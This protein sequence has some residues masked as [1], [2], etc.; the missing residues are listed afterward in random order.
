M[1][2]RVL[3]AATI[4]CLASLWMSPAA[5][6]FGNCADDFYM[7][8]FDERLGG[9]NCDI[10][11]TVDIRWSGGSAKMRVIKPHDAPSD[12]NAAMMGRVRELAA[13]VGAAMDQV[14][15]VSIADVTVLMTGMRPTEVNLVAQADIQRKPGLG[16]ECAVAFYKQPTPVS[17]DEFVFFYAHELFHCI[18]YRT[19]PAA[20]DAAHDLWWTEGTAEYFAHLARPGTTTGDA[21]VQNFDVRSPSV[22]LLQMQY[23]NVVFFAWLAQTQGPGAIASFAR[24]MSPGA[25]QL[26]AL[27]GA[28]S[29]DMWLEFAKAYLDRRIQLPGGR[30]LPSRPLMGDKLDVYSTRDLPLP[31]SP[32]VL[33]RETVVFKRGHKYQLSLNGRPDDAR[34]QW[35]KP[36]DGRWGDTPSEI[37][38]CDAD[39]D[40]RVLWLTTR[41]STAGT[42][43]VRAGEH[44]SV[45]NCLVGSWEMTQAS[46][47]P[48]AQ[49]V[50]CKHAQSCT[51]GGSLLLTFNGDVGAN[52]A[53]TGTYAYNGVT[54][55]GRM[56]PS[57]GVISFTKRFDG[58]GHTRWYTVQN[59]LFMS[60]TD[61]FHPVGTVHTRTV[62]RDQGR[63]SVKDEPMLA[64]VGLGPFLG[65]RYD[66]HGNSLH[67]GEPPGYGMNNYSFDFLRV[68]GVE[69][70]AHQGSGR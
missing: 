24:S 25:G 51:V 68:S 70:G 53:A 66:C 6:A 60:F 38:P 17:V 59:V 62:M 4:A 21:W 30:P 34:V 54:V 40:Y 18:Q 12:E 8:T 23:E 58:V 44:K 7:K 67:I 47:F 32:Y 10:I 35:A 33:A 16:R 48:N 5:F 50:V 14:G 28:V 2:A 29:S 36:S 3:L 41:S 61:L 1:H 42:V 22:S 49:E 56:P 65:G 64:G 63:V 19:W 52:G 26:A 9:M 15:H 69:N 31:I 45:C 27:Q 46:L 57:S 39:E 13:R 43:K 37:D 11:G 20:M 55:E